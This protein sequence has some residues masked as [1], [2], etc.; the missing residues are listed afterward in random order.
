[1]KTI[2]FKDFE[3]HFDDFI[4]DVAENGRHYKVDLGDGRAVMVIPYEEYEFLVGTY[5]EW[6]NAT[7]IVES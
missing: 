4:D 3:Q 5:E 2:S 1:M 7:Q 6:L